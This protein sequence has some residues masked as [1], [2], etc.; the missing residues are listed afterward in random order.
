MLGSGDSVA[1]T[2]SLDA[3]AKSFT[4]TFPFP[5]GLGTPSDYV[6]FIDGYQDDSRTPR[7][8]SDVDTLGYARIR[9]E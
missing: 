7:L 6:V 5:E 8:G 9:V 4:I 3:A 2:Y 1:D